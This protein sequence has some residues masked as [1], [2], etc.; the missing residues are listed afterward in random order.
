[1]LFLKVG[2]MKFD[3]ERF[4][5]GSEYNCSKRGYLW[6]EITYDIFDHVP[7]WQIIIPKYI[8][9]AV[10]VTWKHCLREEEIYMK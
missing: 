7:D 1:M 10:Y 9:V 4:Y 5:F 2:Q 8:Y 3:V 6:D